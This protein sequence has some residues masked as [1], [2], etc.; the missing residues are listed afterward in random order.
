MRRHYLAVVYVGDEPRRYNSHHKNERPP[1]E[2][3]PIQVT[4][5]EDAGETVSPPTSGNVAT[6]SGEAATGEGKSSDA[7]AEAAPSEG[8]KKR[9]GK[10]KQEETEQAKQE[11]K[12]VD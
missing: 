12:K 11:E 7:A 2:A 6:K 10:K 5:P 8:T 1:L 4:P 3:L 9:K